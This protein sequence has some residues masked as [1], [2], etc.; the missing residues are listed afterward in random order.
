[1]SWEFA[2]KIVVAAVFSAG[3]IGAII[4]GVTKN[5]VS[6]IADN[7]ADS[8]QQK[9][10]TEFEKL[11]EEY[12]ARLDNLGHI[13]KTY[14][15]IETRTYQ[16]LCSAFYLMISAV[17]WL[18]PTGLDRAPAVGDLHELCNARYKEA[19]KTYNDAASLLGSKAPFIDKDMYN[20]F[21]GILELS[22]RQIHTYA[23]ANP[24]SMSNPNEH[25]TNI[26]QKGYERTDEIDAK[27]NELLDKMREYISSL[28]L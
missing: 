4:W 5:L 24:E 26:A 25:Y 27:W 22:A 19:Q 3:G 12:K 15:D 2:F 6:R 10:K 14:F 16:E 23:I 7:I 11:L 28:K 18:Y 9:R 13:S 8:I 20:I 21:H 1:M 17:H